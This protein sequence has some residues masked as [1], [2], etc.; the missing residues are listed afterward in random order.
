MLHGF[1]VCSCTPSAAD[2]PTQTL[3]DRLLVSVAAPPVAG[4]SAH[5]CA[6]PPLHVLADAILLPF[7]F[8]WN[9]RAAET[10]GAKRFGFY[11]LELIDQ[12]QDVESKLHDE[13]PFP[14]WI[15]TPQLDDAELEEFGAGRQLTRDLC[16]DA[17]KPADYVDVEDAD[18][19]LG[20]LL[21]LRDDDAD[22]GEAVRQAADVAA[23]LAAQHVPADDARGRGR[24]TAASYAAAPAA[25]R[26]R[27]LPT[28]V[29]TA[30]A[31]AAEYLRDKHHLPRSIMPLAFS[32]KSVALFLELMPDFLPSGNRTTIDYDSFC[33]AYNAAVLNQP[34]ADDGACLTCV[35]WLK[36]F[37]E[38]YA[39]RYATQ[40]AVAPHLEDV[41]ALW[42]EL[43]SSAA[44][45]TDWDD[46]T[47]P[48]PQLLHQQDCG[49]LRGASLETMPLELGLRRGGV[50]PKQQPAPDITAILD[51]AFA[52]AG[53]A[54]PGWRSG[55]QP[56][57]AM[58]R[59]MVAWL[60]AHD[61]ENIIRKVTKGM[62][63]V[64]GLNTQHH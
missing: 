7:M 11:T 19:A 47:A 35:S 22:P 56:N 39:K 43:A 59:G 51:S 17:T 3:L 28:G 54:I 1:S 42:R 27:A 64:F 52:A 38:A 44:S 48:L 5:F 63:R 32:D 49:G 57:A 50:R 25:G 55:P 30:R 8:G 45:V 9:M 34:T 33:N 40:K 29:S 2:V 36:S 46:A 41:K 13:M 12:L 24:R 4:G 15:R 31:S 14:E 60:E 53:A 62:V 61:Y 37:C 21:G 26:R 18:D 23:E 6:P 20:A 58:V 16:L 10:K